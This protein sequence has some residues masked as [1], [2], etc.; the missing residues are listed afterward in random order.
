MEKIGTTRVTSIK[1][2]GPFPMD[3]DTHAQASA[4][5]ALI[6]YAFPIL[7]PLDS[8]ASGARP[9]ITRSHEITVF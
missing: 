2:R 7:F 3:L 6:G 4:D 1:S 5:G 9:H 8:S